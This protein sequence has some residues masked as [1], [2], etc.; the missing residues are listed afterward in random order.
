MAQQIRRASAGRE[1]LAA[2][3]IRKKVLGAVRN[4]RFG[5]P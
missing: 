3:A 5:Q 1:T 4:I 2:E